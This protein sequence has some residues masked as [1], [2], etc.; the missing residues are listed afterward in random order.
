WLHNLTGCASCGRSSFMVAIPLAL[1]VGQAEVC[2]DKVNK[3]ASFI[4]QMAAPLVGQ[5][6]WNIGQ[7]PIMQQ[8]NQAATDD[9]VK[10]YKI[11]LN[12]DTETSHCGRTHDFGIVRLQK[13]L[14]LY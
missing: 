3:G 6:N 7:A 4:G 12:R 13:T 11:G 5:I 14:Y 1:V 2:G 9:I 10:N 8:R